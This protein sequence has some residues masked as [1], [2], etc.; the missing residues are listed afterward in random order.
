MEESFR[1][2]LIS[3]APLV[4][5]VGSDIYWNTIAQGAGTDAV[6]MYLIGGGP[7]YHLQGPDGLTENR[8]QVDARADKLT[9]AWAIARTIKARLSG[10]R[11][12]EGATFFNGIFL[13]SERQDYDNPGN[14]AQAYHRVSL[15][16][17]IWSRAAD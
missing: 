3:S 7:G 8:V 6:V 13:L 11:G 15:D 12:S 17:Q 10:Y 9:D 4:A 1:A 16:F 5:I 2:L 14:G